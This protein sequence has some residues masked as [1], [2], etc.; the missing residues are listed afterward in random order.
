MWTFIKTASLAFPIYAALNTVPAMAQT[1][2]TSDL[3]DRWRNAVNQIYCPSQLSYERDPKTNTHFDHNDIL[4][5]TSAF[6]GNSIEQLFLNAGYSPEEA[7]IG[8]NR[9]LLEFDNREVILHRVLQEND[10]AT[11]RAETEIAQ[12]EGNICPVITKVLDTGYFEIVRKQSTLRPYWQPHS[13][14]A[15][16]TLELKGCG[17]VF[18][19]GLF[20]PATLA[21]WKEVGFPV[22]VG[23]LPSPGDV[24]SAS[25]SLT[26]CDT[27]YEVRAGAVLQACG[28]VG[29]DMMPDTG[30]SD[31]AQRH[32][33]LM[34]AISYAAS[35][36]EF[37]YYTKAAPYLACLIQGTSHSYDD[38]NSLLTPVAEALATV[39]LPDEADWATYQSIATDVLSPLLGV[40]TKDTLAR[41]L[42]QTVGPNHSTQRNLLG[43]AM[44]ER[45]GT[46]LPLE[47]VAMLADQPLPLPQAISALGNVMRVSLKRWNTA[48]SQPQWG[49]SDPNYSSRGGLRLDTNLMM[50]GGPEFYDAIAQIDQSQSLRH[51]LLSSDLDQLNYAYGAMIME[52]LT[53]SGRDEARA[54]GHFSAAADNA[55]A[56]S[57]FR[58]ALMHEY[59]LGIEASTHEA[60]LLYMRAAAGGDPSAYLALAQKSETGKGLERNWN[61]AAKYYRHALEKMDPT[62]AAGA[63]YSRWFDNT[64]FWSPGEP[65]DDLLQFVISE[66]FRKLPPEAEEDY[67][68]IQTRQHYRDIATAIGTLFADAD[69]GQH[70]DLAKAAQWLRVGQNSGTSWEVAETDQDA[71]RPPNP[72]GKQLLDVL[73]IAP[74]LAAHPMEATLLAQQADTTWTNPDD[75]AEAARQMRADCPLENREAHSDCANQLRQAAL[76]F[77]DASLIAPAFDHL[78]AISNLEIAEIERFG[79]L[80]PN[81]ENR[82][83]G[84]GASYNRTPDYTFALVDVLAFFGDYAQAERL[85]QLARGATISASVAPLRRQVARAV[86]T[87]EDVKGLGTLLTTA[88]Q[89]GNSAARDLLAVLNGRLDQAPMQLDLSSARDRFDGLAHLTNSLAMATSARRLA[90][91]ESAAGNTDRAAELELVALAADLE[92]HGAARGTNGPIGTALA[93]VCSLS[94]TSERLFAY[95]APEMA[96]VIAKQ[97][98]NRLQRTRADLS[99]LPERVQLCFRSQV[100]DHYR[101]LAELLISQNRPQEASRV[102]EMLKDFEN[103]EFASRSAGLQGDAYDTLPF[104][105]AELALQ[106][107]M[108]AVRLPDRYTTTR[109]IELDNLSD[110]RAL[111]S[112]ELQEQSDLRQA[113][114]VNVDSANR[115]R[116]DLKT[117]A[118]NVRD[119]GEA[120]DFTQDK[121]I[122]RYLR[123]RGTENAAILQYVVLQDRFGLVLSTRSGQT[124]WTWNQI[125]NSAFSENELNAMVKNFRDDVYYTNRDPRPLGKKLYDLLLPPDVQ[126]ELSSQGIDTLV[127]SLDRQLRYLPMAALHDGK[128]WLSQSYVLSHVSVGTA[129]DG[130]VPQSDLIAGFGATQALNG[131]PALPAVRT[132]VNAVVQENASDA[133]FLAGSAL[134]DQDFNRETL[135]TALE[136]GGT[137]SASGVLHLASHFKIG[138]TEAESALL[139]GDG[140]F[141][142]VR[143][144]REGIGH[145]ANLTRVG[146]L[147]L[148]ACETGFGTT[149]ADGRELESVAAIAQHRGAKSVMASLLPVPDGAT[150]ALMVEFYRHYADGIPPARAIQAAQVAVMS[151]AVDATSLADR[152]TFDISEIDD[153]QPEVEAQLE[154]W[155][156]PRFWASFILLEGSL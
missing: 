21:R 133:G 26:T 39:A 88:T 99:A 155:Q 28:E 119:Q 140:D 126:A 97:A 17:P 58:L 154:G 148:S 29:Y 27:P 74:H 43:I 141:L 20:G 72:G 52:G 110:L 114:A 108:Q 150:A 152:G 82:T 19:D 83:N 90:M 49:Q 96:L 56:P 85:A 80:Q 76:G 145:G 84:Q 135:V 54:L 93:D 75:P 134:F 8:L 113:R 31:V 87:G 64:G 59:G 137:S 32:Q 131:L 61:D 101:W 60:N 78:T 4:A 91:L 130:A 50:D 151:G 70:L 89:L 34:G 44:L 5:L 18:V 69:S 7:Q 13:E 92:R 47:N 128:T 6:S 112:Q 40:R 117:M 138:R 14:Y 33:T 146:L 73:R 120:P 156:H 9:G 51:T 143:E 124:T 86:E 37:S 139:L 65:G 153:S 104:S 122:A 41:A 106:N 118:L 144:L 79:R 2:N 105:S 45:A 23:T 102:L 12:H 24:I 68:A 63:I 48:L 15:Q 81:E 125:G 55:H 3:A 22:S 1:D 107:A 116:L 129:S 94:K 136:F 147:T 67:T 132:E 71:Y 111:T 121:L 57:L 11:R 36:S 103:F 123:S 46:G 149:G 95:G 142:S 66:A 109:L 100:E 53:P 35:R 38:D 98:V 30:L 42:L 115:A 77:Y 10:D 62:A 127:L 16:M 25:R